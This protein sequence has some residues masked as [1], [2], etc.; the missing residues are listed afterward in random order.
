[1]VN[2]KILKYLTNFSQIFFIISDTSTIFSVYGSTHRMPHGTNSNNP[3]TSS[4]N[5][6]GLSR[7]LLHPQTFWTYRSVFPMVKFTPKLSRNHS[8][9]IYT[10]HQ[11][12]PTHQVALRALLL[13]KYCDTGSKIH[14][15]RTL[16]T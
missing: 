15:K 2:T 9:Y 1:M 3:L 6:A 13:E 8:T 7:T 14:N 10:F 4:D 11:L 5:Y 12:L 16:S